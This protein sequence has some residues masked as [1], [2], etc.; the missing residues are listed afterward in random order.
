MEYIFYTC[1]LTLGIW[2]G[3]QLGRA[4]RRVPPTDLQRALCSQRMNDSRVA[5]A[6]ET[7][8]LL[9]ISRN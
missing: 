2:I 8:E 7:A 9:N 6:L 1:V 4:K 5:I 3:F